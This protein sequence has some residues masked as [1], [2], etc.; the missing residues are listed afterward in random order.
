MT[1]VTCKAG[2]GLMLAGRW[3]EAAGSYLQALQHGDEGLGTLDQLTYKVNM[4]ECLIKQKWQ[5]QRCGETC[6][7]IFAL[8]AWPAPTNVCPVGQRTL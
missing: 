6:S 7:G 4:L 8:A 1:T 5:V 3:A 2:E